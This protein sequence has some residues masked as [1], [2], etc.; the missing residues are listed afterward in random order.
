ME[1]VEEVYYYCNQ[2]GYKETDER[3]MMSHMKRHKEDIKRMR[4]TQL[5]NVR[6][7]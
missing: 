2:C 6:E 3:K 1:L 7:Q 5:D 4:K